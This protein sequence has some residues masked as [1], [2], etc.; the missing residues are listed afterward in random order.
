MFVNGQP[1]PIE[2]GRSLLD[3]LAGEGFDVQTVVVELN[4][5]I[6]PKATHAS[7]IL[8]DADTLEIVS[9]VGGG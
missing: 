8:A 9:F 3:F 4:G 2:S 5:A 1:V 7:V 6:V